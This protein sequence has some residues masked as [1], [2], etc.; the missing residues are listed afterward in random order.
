MVFT[1]TI[2]MMKKESIITVMHINISSEPIDRQYYI[3][4]SPVSFCCSSNEKQVSALFWIRYNLLGLWQKASEKGNVFLPFSH[5]LDWTFIIQVL[6]SLLLLLLSYNSISEELE[7]KT[8]AL[9]ASN[10]ISRWEIYVF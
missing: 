3:S 4:P 5:T 1:L 7:S 2:G 6:F 9:I 10:S 8:L